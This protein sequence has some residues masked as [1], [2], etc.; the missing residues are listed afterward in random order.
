MVPPAHA[1]M[2]KCSRWS[3]ASL[4]RREALRTSSGTDRSHHPSRPHLF[5]ASPLS[6]LALPVPHLTS[7]DG[8]YI[9]ALFG[10][11]E[12]SRALTVPLSTLVRAPLAPSIVPVCRCC[13]LPVPHCCLF[14]PTV[15][16]ALS[17]K[18]LNGSIPS[19]CSCFTVGQ[20]SLLG[21]DSS[22]DAG[23]NRGRD[24]SEHQSIRD[25]ERDRFLCVFRTARFLCTAFALVDA[26][27]IF[28]TCSQ[29]KARMVRPAASACRSVFT[30]GG[31]SWCV[32]L[33]ML[34]HRQRGG[35]RVGG[36]RGRGGGSCHCGDGWGSARG[37]PWH[38]AAAARGGPDRGE[39]RGGSLDGFSRIDEVRSSPV[40]EHQLLREDVPWGVTML[41]AKEGLSFGRV[42][43][44]VCLSV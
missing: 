29:A 22:A 37:K 18:K 39:S 25:T 5:L 35:F 42:C 10:S 27:D 43:L 3:R 21:R 16:V 36:L 11:A 40:M 23:S 7:S 15:V 12:D 17:S 28:Q 19:V 24:V 6:C 13:P 1:A 44:C 33:P 26:C 2:R 14:S 38:P 4:R 32:A 34:Q 9:S 8:S 20:K 31:S 30:V 41:S